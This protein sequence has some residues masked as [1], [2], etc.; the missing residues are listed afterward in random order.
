[1]RISEFEV[2][3]AIE[4]KDV[5]LLSRLLSMLLCVD[6]RVYVKFDVHFSNPPIN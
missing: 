5:M 6:I 3:I 2:L 4:I 1:M